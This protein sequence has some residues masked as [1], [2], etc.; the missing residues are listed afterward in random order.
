[1][2]MKLQQN[3]LLSGAELCAAEIA[4]LIELAVKLKAERGKKNIALDNQHLALLFAKPSLR[5]RFSFTVAMGELGGRVVESVT[6]TRKYETPSDQM[7]VIQGYCHGLM[8]RT[9]SDADIEAMINVAKI[10]VINGL[11]ELYHPCQTLADLM[12]IYE[13]FG[14][15][16]GIKVCYIGDGNNILHSL[17]LMAPKLGIQVNYCCP[18]GLEPKDVVLK[19]IENTTLV[20]AFNSPDEAV[21]DCDAIYTDVWCSMGFDQQDE[22][23]FEGF[24]VNETLMQKAK[25][26]AIFMHCMPIERGNEV[27]ESLPD[28]VCSVIFQQSENRLHAQKAVLLSIMGE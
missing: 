9:H 27:S 12:T 28:S 10:P 11:S 13:V 20:Q 8:I 25:Q 14:K 15:Y 22:S 3:Y 6:D 21:V 16:Q 17:L 18:K 4:S 1:M 5:T 2:K 24:Q 19:Q 7:Q 23:L 26:N